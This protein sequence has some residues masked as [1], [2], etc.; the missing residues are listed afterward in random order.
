MIGNFLVEFL[1]IHPF[2]DGNGRLSRVLTNLLLLQAGYLYIPY[3]SHEKLVEDNK[4][5]Y[6]IALRR[7]QKTMGT[8]NERIVDWLH[9]F[10]D[11]LLKQ[12]K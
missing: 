10:L 8:K 2:T 11:I 7:S 3:V 5:E 6:Y 9:F 12:K 4:P 1:K